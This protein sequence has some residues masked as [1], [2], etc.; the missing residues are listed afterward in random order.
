KLGTHISKVKSIGMDQWTKEQIDSMRTT[1]NLNSNAMYNPT[2]VEPPVNL[3]DSER[4][5]ELEKY[6]RNKYQFRKF[7]NLRKDNRATGASSSSRSS[8]HDSGRAEEGRQ[9]ARELLTATPARASSSPQVDPP[10]KASPA[11]TTKSPAPP[12]VSP[13]PPTPSPSLPTTQTTQQ[14][15]L[16]MLAPSPQPPLQVLATFNQPP[17][18]ILS[19]P[20]LASPPPGMI[21]TQT[22]LMPMTTGVY[23]T[24]M[25]TGLPGMSIAAP[26]ALPSN[27][28]VWQDMAALQTGTA[29]STLNHPLHTGL[30][31][32]TTS[33]APNLPMTNNMTGWS[34]PNSL[35]AAS[36][37]IG[38][39]YSTISTTYVQPSQMVQ[40]QPQYAQPQPL[41]AVQQ[42][43]QQLQQPLYVQNGVVMQQPPLMQPS[44]VQGANPMMWNQGGVYGPGMQGQWQG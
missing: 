44:P 2:E 16:Q 37:P 21:L 9:R 33:F 36:T 6:I 17:L 15:P 24:T 40:V 5:S 31:Y 3:H 12:T 32:Q 35:V 18:Q 42:Q 27:N 8:A 13:A 41:Y 11:L 38:T 14:P 10:R 1:G 34:N 22:G 19:Q 39:T 25:Y 26:P 28:P 43:Q 20:I 23:Q 4:D 29:Q 7:I 30:P